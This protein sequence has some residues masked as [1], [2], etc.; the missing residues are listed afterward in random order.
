MTRKEED[1][2][3]TVRAYLKTLDIRDFEIEGSCELAHEAGPATGRANTLS[4]C[5]YLK[6]NLLHTHHHRHNN[7]HT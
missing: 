2:R 5:R 1:N 6:Q 4:I 7:H 3:M